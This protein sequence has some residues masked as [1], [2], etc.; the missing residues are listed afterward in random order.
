MRA[1]YGRDKKAAAVNLVRAV[2]RKL[3]ALHAL[4]TQDL[5]CIE[6][7]ETKCTQDLHC[8]RDEMHTTSTLLHCTE[9]KSTKKKC[10]EEICTALDFTEGKCSA[11]H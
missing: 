3:N 6:S 11:R 5:Q 7:I 1:V 8:N 10:N 2:C 4:Q 9:I